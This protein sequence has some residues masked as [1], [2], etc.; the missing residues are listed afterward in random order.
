MVSF[1]SYDPP[2]NMWCCSCSVAQSHPT[3]LRPHGLQPARFLC[4]LDSPVKNTGVVCDFL[5]QGSSQPQDQ[6]PISSSPQT[7]SP[8]DLIPSHWQ[9]DSLLSNQGSLEIYLS[10]VE[11]LWKVISEARSSFE[12]IIFLCL[13]KQ[14]SKYMEIVK[15]ER[16]MVSAHFFKEKLTLCQSSLTLQLY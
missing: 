13:L 11:M 7:P 6:T 12:K 9:A 2:E 8:Q 4:P 15:S 1:P 10:N 14:R 16:R 5:L 3:L